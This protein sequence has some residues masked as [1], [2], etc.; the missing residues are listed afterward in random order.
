ME[1]DPWMN[2]VQNQNIMKDPAK[3][4]E[5]LKWVVGYIIEHG[6][7][8]EWVSGPILIKKATLNFTVKFW[9]TVV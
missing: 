1:Y 6:V 9:W 2:I 3:K 4:Q 8:A 7:D 5:V